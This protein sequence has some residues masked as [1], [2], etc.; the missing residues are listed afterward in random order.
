MQNI[1][2]A[3]HFG[4]RQLVRVMCETQA[5]PFQRINLLPAMALKINFGPGAGYIGGRTFFLAFNS[6]QL[7]WNWTH[8]NIDC[9]ATS[10]R[11]F[12]YIRWELIECG[13]TQNANIPP[14][15]CH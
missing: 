8:R 5:A 3:I 14:Y 1:N 7:K 4:K 11:W 12:E 15:L 13:F 6:G 10:R 2:K 9:Q